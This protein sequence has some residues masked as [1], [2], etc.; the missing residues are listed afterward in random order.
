MA[1]Q[2]VI[3]SV[4]MVMVLLLVSCSNAGPDSGAESPPADDMQTDPAA[5]TQMQ[6]NTAFAVQTTAGT[7]P[8]TVD[9]WEFSLGF[10]GG[11]DHTVVVDAPAIAARPA[12][13]IQSDA[14]QVVYE[15]PLQDT[16]ASCTGTA[17]SDQLSMY[18]F[19]FGDGK[20][21]FSLDLTQGD[22]YR[23]ILYADLSAGRPY[24]HWRAAE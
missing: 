6:P 24:V 23:D 18:S 5:Q 8:Q 9:L 22:G 17:Q 1:I 21:R 7:C 10:E 13:I 4:G 12:T 15:A 11:A 14:R 20:V 19:Q 16:Y 2:S 3:G